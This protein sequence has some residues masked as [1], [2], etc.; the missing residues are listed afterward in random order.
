MKVK[1]KR[2]SLWLSVPLVVLT[3]CLALTV[4]QFAPKFSGGSVLTNIFSISGR[5][6]VDGKAAHIVEGKNN[7]PPKIGLT[8]SATASPLRLTSPSQSINN[9]YAKP[10]ASTV[11]ELVMAEVAAA[12]SK[13]GLQIQAW[14]K[15]KKL[16]QAYA[17]LLA[18]AQTGDGDAMFELSNV[19]Q[20]CTSPQ[21][22]ASRDAALMSP[23]CDTVPP[24]NEGEALRWLALAARE[25]HLL[26]KSRLLY[27]T[28][29]S[30]S[31]ASYLSLLTADPT[32]HGLLQQ[33]ILDSMRLFTEIPR[34]GYLEQAASI[35]S[36]G[37]VPKNPELAFA[38]RLAAYSLN[39]EKFPNASIVAFMGNDLT[40]AFNALTI[41]Q[42]S[43]ATSK[44]A[45]ILKYCCSGLPPALDFAKHRK[46]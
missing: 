32:L 2:N 11:D 29:G 38:Y 19:M 31:S 26:A 28:S 36:D 23:Q 37:I 1:L 44:A 30:E 8:P 17:S 6:E 24:N 40:R 12:K 9:R 46:P 16:G 21:W 33:E 10:L 7:S 35:Y 25:G 43:N 3:I 15:E 42:Q 41:E 45:E 22:K 27:L 20:V 14:F 13:I 5:N 18:Q 39:N 4:V 34:G